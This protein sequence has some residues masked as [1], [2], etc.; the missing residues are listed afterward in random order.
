MQVLGTRP[1]SGIAFVPQMPSQT[2]KA[3]TSNGKVAAMASSHM[4]K[5][6]ASF[7]SLDSLSKELVSL[8]PIYEGVIQPRDS[9][10]ADLTHNVEIMR[11]R[12]WSSTDRFDER[13]DRS[14]RNQQAAVPIYKFMRNRD[15]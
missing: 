14:S 2:S 6:T 4:S 3:K 10:A 8:L 12:S 13:A 11:R 5:T 9:R 1:F 7:M 15:R